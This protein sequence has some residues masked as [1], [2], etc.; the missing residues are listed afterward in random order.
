MYCENKIIK[1]IAAKAVEDTGGLFV[2]LTE[3]DES[4]PIV[5]SRPALR[6]G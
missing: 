1:Q 5:L 6:S 2:A 4:I 3:D